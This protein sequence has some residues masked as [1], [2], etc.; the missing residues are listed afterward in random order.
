MRVLLWIILLAIFAFGFD[1]KIATFNA[2]NLFD[3]KNHGSEYQDFTIGKSNWSNSQYI[4]KS[5]NLA[6]FLN[7]VDADI[8]AL[9]EIENEEVLE[10]LANKS[11]YKFYKFTKPNNSPF[12]VGVISKL[13]INSSNYYRF[14]DIIARDILKT[15]FNVDGFSFSLF[16]VHLL[17][18]K[19]PKNEKQK[20]FDAL[21]KF[22]SGSENSIILGDFNEDFSP[23]YMLKPFEDKY[24]N[25]WKEKF[26]FERVSHISGRAID[27]IFLSKSFLDSKLNIKKFSVIK[28]G[29]L[30]D[31]YM[32]LLTLTTQ[33]SQNVPKIASNLDEIYRL[34]SITSPLFL[35]K[36][37]V[38]YSDKFGYS[39][40]QEN[41]RGIYIY[42]KDSKLNVGDMVD[43]KIN[44]VGEYK[45]NLEVKDALVEKI[46]DEK[47][48]LNS[49]T[50]NINSELKVGDTILSVTG[51]VINGRLYHPK[52]NILI[53]SKSGGKLK[54]SD[55][56]MTF[57]NAYII[58][59]GGELELLVR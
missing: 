23:T 45:G 53:Y 9:Q 38:T 36:V 1:F 32:L 44:S 51:K 24:I 46:Y 48:N 6:K 4:R 27:H 19:N 7:E 29:G 14:S 41:G 3:G 39:I 40:A 56:D 17:S 2:E 22:V 5:D 52:G 31:H 37:A 26:G 25:L 47:A 43:I 11:K 21:L 18:Q 8:V 33:K 58:N 28:S 20:E 16:T 55:R 13:P 57:N 35:E 50:K 59:F 34:G 15:D 30:S 42:D 54:N 49:Y 10:R 12:G